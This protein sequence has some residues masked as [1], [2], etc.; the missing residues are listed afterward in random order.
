MKV[1]QQLLRIIRE[2]IEAIDYGVVKITVNKDGNY[3]E[4][5]TERKTRIIKNP[6]ETELHHG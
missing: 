6:D 2:E 3:T 4:I 1:N 5:S